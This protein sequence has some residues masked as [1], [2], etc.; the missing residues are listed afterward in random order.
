[1]SVPSEVAGTFPDDGPIPYLTDDP[2]AA[3]DLLGR[4]QLGRKSGRWF[5]GTYDDAIGAIAV[6]GLIPSCWR[7]GDTCAVFGAA[8]RADVAGSRQHD[9]VVEVR[10]VTLP[11]D[12]RSWWVPP[13]AIRGAWRGDSFVDHANLPRAALDLP[14]PDGCRCALTDVCRRQQQ[15]WADTWT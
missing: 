10:S 14:A 6:S 11:H 3:L 1:M 4:R 13:Q 2:A 7:G 12:L 8:R 15:E 5:H 9:W